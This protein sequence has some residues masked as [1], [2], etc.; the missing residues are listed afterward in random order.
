M[1]R[2]FTAVQADENRRFLT[3]LARTGN[4]RLSA[5]VI[6]KAYGTMQH[7]RAKHPVFATK[8]DAAV[9]AAQARLARKGAVRPEARQPGA[10]PSRGS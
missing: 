5:R 2:L 9:V 4:A 7:R 8:W 3:E 10:R 1:A 6:G